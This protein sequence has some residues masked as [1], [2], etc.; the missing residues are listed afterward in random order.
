MGG[1]T[2]GAKSKERNRPRP[3][4]FQFKDRLGEGNVGRKRGWR[5]DTGTGSLSQVPDGLSGLCGVGIV[6]EADGA[7]GAWCCD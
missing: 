2:K 4:M 7:E 3:G 1:E 6:A 5:R